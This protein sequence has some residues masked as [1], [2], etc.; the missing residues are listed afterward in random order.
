[1]LPGKKTPSK[2]VSPASD[3]FKPAENRNVTGFRVTNGTYDRVFKLLFKCPV[4]S[5]YRHLLVECLQITASYSEN[6]EISQATTAFRGG[7]SDMVT[8]I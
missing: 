6:W 7:V 2:T 3:R 1:M 8:D 4:Q 5:I